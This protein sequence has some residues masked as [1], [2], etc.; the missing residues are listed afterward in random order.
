MNKE[1]TYFKILNEAHSDLE[2]ELR[3][4]QVDYDKREEKR[5]SISPKNKFFTDCKREKVYFAH[6]TVR[7]EE[8]FETSKLLCSSGCLVGSV[9]FFPVYQSGKNEYSPHNLGKYIF[10]KEVSFFS[11]KQKAPKILL[12]EIE[13][14][15]NGKIAGLNYLKLG[16]F[17]F[18][19]FIER[20]RKK[21]Y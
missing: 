8:I 2:Q 6:I 9:F 4:E 10:Q 14:T 15:K 7:E 19:V 5:G 12:I 18:K 13:N 1:K 16:E 20:R 3:F 17:H 11:E 21:K